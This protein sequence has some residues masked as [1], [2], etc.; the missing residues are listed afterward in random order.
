[1]KSILTPAE[2]RDFERALTENGIDEI[3]LMRRAAVG[4]FD[5]AS[6]W[7]GKV[8]ILCGGGNNAGDGY[9]LALMLKAIGA[10]PILLRASE[11]LTEASAYYYEKC[12]ALAIEERSP[13][14][15]DFLSDATRLVDCLFGIGFHG[16]LS[17][18]YSDI[19][20]WCNTHA[21]PVIAA[22]IP[23]G[24][25]ALTGAVE[26]SA[27]SGV[28]KASMTVAVGA[29]KPGHFFGL[30]PDLC[31]TL[32]LAPLCAEDLSATALD[33]DNPVCLIE[34]ADI[35]PLFATRPHCSHKGSYGTTLL[36]GG[37]DEYGGAPKLANLAAAS[38]ASLRSGCGIAR[39]AVPE[40]LVHAVA[41]YLLE[42]TLCPM[43][44]AE[45]KLTFDQASLDRAFTGVR[46]A[47]V[48]MGWGRSN[49]YADVLGYILSHFDIPTV[50]DADGLNTLA[51]AV[52]LLDCKRH[53]PI[54]LTP[55]PKEFERLSGIAMAQVLADPIGWARTFAEAHRCIVLLKGSSTVIT[56]GQ[57]VYL[58]NRGCGGMATA[59]SGDVLSGVLASLL[60]WS[61]LDPL[62]TVAAGA[63]LAGLAGEI[64]QGRVGSLSMVASDT[65]A[66]LPEASL[67]IASL[68]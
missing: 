51:Q 19:A 16:V 64:A 6:P 44:Q 18:P 35:A 25:N 56:D 24:L 46:S 31:G 34:A 45:G 9:A 65:V 13:S 39:L 52:D 62:I 15:I 22:D 26:G 3:E 11:K 58:T 40:T 36:L 60:A 21:I 66:A 27:D 8:G 37:C 7:C 17:A 47:A 20:H 49:E 23:S 32:A 29:Y 48:G 59:G 33:H 41:P 1:M 68:L 28:I 38:L 50:I 54:V 55:H 53:S 12:R 57:K 63:Y 2:M 61:P 14:K 5:A 4:I 43:P 67:K 30:A 10:R 42:S